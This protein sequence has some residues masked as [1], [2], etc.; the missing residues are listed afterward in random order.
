[1]TRAIAIIIDAKT[2]YCR[3]SRGDVI[4]VIPALSLHVIDAYAGTCHAKT[5]LTHR[6]HTAPSR[7]VIDVITRARTPA[8]RY[9]RII[10]IIYIG[11][12]LSHVII[13]TSGHAAHRYSHRTRL[14]HV[15]T[16]LIA[17]IATSSTRKLSSPAIA[18]VRHQHT[19][20]RISRVIVT[21]PLLVISTRTRHGTLLHALH[22]ATRY[23][24]VIDAG[25]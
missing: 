25:A 18:H 13:A 16:L 2:C 22:I 19:R 24:H 23:R 5:L 7:V 12:P 15:N 8:H 3:L 1:M 4:I 14:T 9:Y 6:R 21:S 17:I 11:I 10:A 20:H